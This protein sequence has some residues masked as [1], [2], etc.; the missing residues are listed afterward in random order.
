MDFNLTDDQTALQDLARTFAQAELAP[1]S[2][3]WDAES[4]F[5]TDVLRQAASLGFAGLY[6]AEDVGGSNLTR[7]DAAII[8]EALAEGDVIKM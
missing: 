3:K 4:Y 8:F 6:V 2:A 1:N 5:P 7:L